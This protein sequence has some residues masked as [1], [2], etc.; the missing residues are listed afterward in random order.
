MHRFTDLESTP[1]R[2]PPVYGYLAHQLLP[3]QEAVKPILPQIDQLERFSSIAKTECHFPSEHGLT[4]DESAAIYLYTMEWGGNSFYQVINRALRAEDRVS[5]MPWFAYLKLFDTAVEKLPTLRMN[6][7]RGVPEDVARNFKNGDEF[8]WWAISSCS[9]SLGT[10]ENFLGPNSTVFLIEAINGKD[11]SK[12][13][14]FPAE[15]EVILCPGTR[16]RVKGGSQDQTST[17]IIH[18]QEITTHHKDEQPFIFQEIAPNTFTTYTDSIG[19][20]KDGE[21]HGEGKMDYTD[22]SKLFIYRSHPIR[23][24]SKGQWRNDQKHGKGK[25]TWGPRAEKAGDT[26]KGDYSNDMISGQGIYIYANGNRYEFR[27]S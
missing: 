14:N 10:I 17:R 18:L 7:W 9:K 6:L 5:L 15:T 23:E 12:Y 20:I 4:R 25:I 26:Y 1:R 22:G 21:K 3:L 24:Y 19:Q 27:Y 2:L 8:T 13:T 16:L 11:I